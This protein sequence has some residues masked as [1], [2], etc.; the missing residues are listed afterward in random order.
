MRVGTAP[1]GGLIIALTFVVGFLLSMLPGPEWAE[2]FRPDWVGL[3]LIYWCI[4]AP[5]RVGVVVG[6]LVGLVLDILYGSLLGQHALAMA[7]IAFIVHRLHLQIRM[8]P[9]W[10]QAATVLMLLVLNQLLVLWVKGLIG[11]ASTLWPNWTA[12][13]V[14]TVVWP[15]VF[16]ILRDV[17]RR[18]H[19]N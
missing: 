14:G 6:W 15:L 12:S 1:R 2:R 19:I 10:Q 16:V 9:P 5:N 17:R 4:A 7:I 18:A 11:Q 13:V 3:V 8:F